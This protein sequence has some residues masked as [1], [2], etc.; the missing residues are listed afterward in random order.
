MVAQLH[1]LSGPLSVTG[2]LQLSPAGSYQLDGSV[3]PKPGTS[4]E[5]TQKLQM[6]GPPDAQGRHAFSIAGS[7]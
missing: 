3:T 7:L 6:L 5:L 2:A 1:D 4:A